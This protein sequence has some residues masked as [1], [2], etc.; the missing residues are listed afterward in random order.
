MYYIKHKYI[1]LLAL[2]SLVNSYSLHA[3]ENF[4]LPRPQE[5]ITTHPAPD[6]SPKLSPDNKWLLFTS[7][8]NGNWDIF[9][10]SAAGG[11]PIQITF[12]LSD[13][14]SPAW[15]P[16][17][18][19]I[20]Y[21][22][23]SE[24]AL[25]DLYVMPINLSGSPKPKKPLRIAKNLGFD[26]KPCFASDGK[27]LV[28]LSDRSGKRQIWRYNFK[29]KDTTLLIDYPAVDFDLNADNIAYISIS[30]ETPQGEVF[31]IDNYYSSSQPRQLTFANRIISAISFSPDGSN[32]V[33]ARVLNDSNGDALVNTDDNFTLWITPIQPD[34]S[35]FKAEL[36]L[37]PDSES[38]RE[39]FWGKPRCIYYTNIGKNSADIFKIHDSGFF[40]RK[41][42]AS[43]QLALC[44]DFLK[45]PVYYPLALET[46][47]GFFPDSIQAG[48][49]LYRKARFLYENGQ[50]R[51]A[52]SYFRRVLRDYSADTKLKFLCE[53][54]L[55]QIASG[56][57][58]AS[59]AD[60]G[61]VQ[62]PSGFNTALEQLSAKSPPA[63]VQ[64]EILLL[65][66]N[67][68]TQMGVFSEALTILNTIVADFKDFTHICAES[69]FRIADI[70]SRYGAKSEIIR[71]YL[72]ILIN[73]P[74]EEK[75]IQASIDKIFDMELE[76]NRITGLQK[77][78]DN[79]RLYPQ[80]N[81]A[82]RLHTALILDSL[83]Q[84]DLAIVE[85]Q[86]VLAYA[87]DSSVTASI[88]AKASFILA[89]IYSR[90][91]DFLSASDVLE[92]TIV[93]NPIFTEPARERLF[94]LFS[95]RGLASLQ[96]KDYELALAMF[97][98]SR[99]IYPDRLEGHRGYIAVMNRLYKG[100]SAYAEYADSSRAHPQNPVFIYCQ[101]LALSYIGAS[102][103]DKLIQSI[104]LIEKSLT[105][106]FTMIPAH[107]TL[108]YNYQAL[109]EIR[110]TGT[111]KIPITKRIYKFSA[112]V[113]SK[114]Y[115][116]ITFQG[117]PPEYSG[118]E[119]AINSLN[120]ALLLND[121]SR[122][123]QLEA[124]LYQN[125]ANSY[126]ALGEF[127]FDKAVSAYESMLS[128]SPVFDSHQM[129]SSIYERLG[130]ASMFTEK[131]SQAR[132]YLN[133]A[134]ESYQNAGSDKDV[135]RILLL[136]AENELRSGDGE[137]SN[138]YFKKA[139]DKA[140]SAGL[141]IPSELYF[142]NTAFNWYAA[143]EW[144]SAFDACQKALARLDEQNIPR[145]KKKRYKIDFKILGFPSPVGIPIPGFIVGGLSIGESRSVEGFALADIK[146]LALSIK[147]AS[148]QEQSEIDLT[149]SIL[150]Q[151]IKLAEFKQDYEERAAALNNLAFLDYQ[152]DSPEQSAHNLIASIESAKKARLS[153]PVYRNIYSLQALIP[154]LPLDS[155]IARNVRY[156]IDNA[157]DAILAEPTDSPERR[158][159]ADVKAL[160]LS[161]EGCRRFDEGNRLFRSQ[162][163]DSIFTG[164]SLLASSADL[165]SL[166]LNMLPSVGSEKDSLILETNLTALQFILGDKDSAQLSF[167]RLLKKTQ[168]AYYPGLEWKIHSL[169]SQTIST[170]NPIEVREKLES[171]LNALT[172]EFPQKITPSPQTLA[173][174]TELFSRLF[175][176]YIEE[177]E[178]DKALELLEL[179]KSLEFSSQLA[180]REFPVKGERRR[181]I[182]ASGGGAVNFL[183][184]EIQRLDLAV[185]LGGLKPSEIAAL[186]D[187][188][189]SCQS[190]YDST[191]KTVFDEDPEFAA[192]FS[193][194]IPSI[195]QLRSA[196][197]ADELYLQLHSAGDKIYL[198]ALSNEEFTCKILPVT[199]DSIRTL[200]DHRDI[201]NLTI[202]LLSPLSDYLDFYSILII[203][204]DENLCSI[205]FEILRWNNLELYRSH[206]ILRTHSYSEFLFARRKRALGGNNLAVLGIPPQLLSVPASTAVLPPPEQKSKS[207]MLNYAAAA[208]IV[209]LRSEFNLRQFPLINASYNIDIAPE[210]PL[211][212]TIYDHFDWE[213]SAPLLILDA[214]DLSTAG[215]EM[216]ARSFIFAGISQIIAVS[217]AA[218]KKL[219]KEYLIAFLD[220]IPTHSPAEA[221]KMALSSLNLP[222]GSHPPA[223]YWGDCGMTPAEKASFARSNFQRTVLLGNNNLRSGAYEWALRYYRQASA[224]AKKLNDNKS[225]NNLLQLQLQAAYKQSDW[226][227][228]I[229]FQKELI[230]RNLPL[231]EEAQACANIAYFFLQDDRPDSAARYIEIS[232]QSYSDLNLN[233]ESAS[234]YKN[235]AHSLEQKNLYSESVHWASKSL[236]LEK[237]LLLPDTLDSQLFL[238]K[239]LLE[240]G[241]PDEA[242][243]YL[244]PLSADTTLQ[245]FSA[246]TACLLSGRC[247]L[248][249][250]DYYSAMEYFEK[251]LDLAPSDSLSLKASAEQGLADSYFR[252][253]NFDS[254]LTHLKLARSYSSS[255]SGTSEIYLTFNTEALIEK[256]LGRLQNSIKLFEQALA[257][258][259]K[260]VDRKSES[261]IRKN[262][263]L[264]LL[265][266]GEL[267]KSISQARQ[268][269]DLD[270]ALKDSSAQYYDLLA[271]TALHLRAGNIDEAEKSLQNAAAILKNP[272]LVANIRF[273]CLQIELYYR[274]KDIKTASSIIDSA[275]SSPFIDN[276]P[277]YKW[278]FYYQQARLEYDSQ[279][280]TAALF[281]LRNAE[282]AL[283]DMLAPYS[284]WESFTAILDDP[285]V[286]FDLAASIQFNLKDYRALLE[287]IEKRRAVEIRFAV[288]ERGLVLRKKQPYS[289]EEISLRARLDALQRKFE[290]ISDSSEALKVLKN[291]QTVYERYN[292]LLSRIQLW[293]QDYYAIISQVP[294]NNH[295][296]IDFDRLAQYLYIK[297]EALID[298]MICD[299]YTFVV[300]VL[301]DSIFA[302]RIPAGFAE[303]H[304]LASGFIQLVEAKMDVSKNLNLFY[305]KLISPLEKTLANSS[306][307]A[308]IPDNP[309]SNIPFEAL[310]DPQGKNL[311]DLY[312]IYYYFSVGH[313][314]VCRDTTRFT[315]NDIAGFSLS[316]YPGHPQLEFADKEVESIAFTIPQMTVYS[317]NKAS[318]ENFIRE[319][320]H[321]SVIHIAC[322]GVSLSESSMD[323]VLLLNSQDDKSLIVR[324]LY[325]MET[326]ASLIF[327]S[328]CGN[329]L[330]DI[331]D[332]FD[333]S[334]PH[335]L[336]TAGASSVI[337]GDWKSGDL[338]SAVLAKRFYRGLSS[339]Y[340]KSR[341]LRE[342]K[343]YVR[344][345]LNSHP[346][347]WA[348]LQLYGNP[349]YL[350][351]FKKENLTVNFGN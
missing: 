162:T 201:Q 135:F 141:E 244:L 150:L 105:L 42:T 229:L 95:E 307:L 305:D 327:L 260:S 323:F 37:T 164:L 158:L 267:P 47:K 286:I 336:I 185:K 221:H 110:T 156:R 24:D 245:S 30:E 318:A 8:R 172:S 5:R 171:A 152:K 187:S 194:S 120:Q 1:L 124:S 132:K 348:H 28:F 113:L 217:P 19:K 301:P 351:L 69:Q 285:D 265:K 59:N 127:G 188:L 239:L 23:N 330:Q 344:D 205:P 302:A 206:T 310:T 252:L 122:Y 46:V 70:Y 345:N 55:L 232:A 334:L 93:E 133:Y 198:W 289:L 138:E 238:G 165:W 319:F 9:I 77:I 32:V 225:L 315:G 312:E 131:F 97:D 270:Y 278:R 115:R 193:T 129:E 114:F 299:D 333:F 26:D 22:S 81:A 71:A 196:Q 231:E 45:V 88:K 17:G 38:N 287:T 90:N 108:S 98:K 349:E 261:I 87:N 179:Q 18:K 159:S 33:T 104:A 10:R 328:T 44:D 213:L 109:E 43:E 3:Q 50:I 276:I 242:A 85:L 52:E 226:K 293:D 174:R 259:Q 181:F 325:G 329:G 40:G 118:Y 350:N 294:Y 235:F 148:L 99:R 6:R 169:R 339:G 145:P 25:G 134:L 195:E 143:G 63:E 335:C 281:N 337:S 303:L 157:V 60:F 126:Y 102:D 92:K 253:N 116:A 160:I 275:L 215:G 130:R 111:E 112:G 200:T 317:A 140:G 41:N 82:A 100:K 78:I 177:S 149:S 184:R 31:F 21:V 321:S 176:L 311:L 247:M 331:G 186:K 36:Q 61:H 204:A 341:A 101:G 57:R 258:V 72:S 306:A 322:H 121:E 219:T 76:A 272:T 288:F 220:N 29:K 309:V 313:Y 13:E 208:D 190:E 103:T 284:D 142:S 51:T 296:Y 282:I 192:L 128:F 202:A 183:R 316:D 254:A 175:S 332:S 73:Y 274:K 207:D 230:D 241:R 80:L 123:P 182:W 308:V 62:N 136:L 66:A 27:I 197:T 48:E 214:V 212:V 12:D 119:L 166:A 280:N 263:A 314:L 15:S 54:S 277:E 227:N 279:N 53:L 34:S 79:Y 4:R 326:N 35:D 251:A 75:W 39:P 137:T 20:A 234:V 14:Y 248:S 237:S 65:K 209:Y 163:P 218:D 233:N 74:S 324:N 180:K 243:K 264:A 173:R 236:E 268:I 153:A 84:S 94:R 340:S 266:N 273:A 49:A 256:N 56:Y 240:S 211:S 304:D 139:L 58:I 191:R 170:F 125:L 117:E 106:D 283:A 189:W 246:F 155:E 290:G 2:I 249:Q 262:Y 167:D 320:A 68:L 64:A 295:T 297:N 342:A 228:A 223:F 257:L 271:L 346:A 224:M 291:R 161:A 67:A 146:S 178:Y 338:A 222:A 7:R 292:A 250:M 300:V 91:K 269:L 96:S 86:Y 144:Q 255:V 11:I 298:Y 147:A 83:N 216:L 154:L 89:D 203:A 347:Y 16:D 210:P 107:L 199:L 168:E 151:K 343:L